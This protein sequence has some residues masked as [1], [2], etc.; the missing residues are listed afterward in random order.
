VTTVEHSPAL[1]TRCAA[2]AAQYDCEGWQR[3]VLAKDPW[4][5]ACNITSLCPAAAV[6]SSVELKLY[7]NPLNPNNPTSL[8]IYRASES[9]VPDYP[10]Q[11]LFRSELTD[12]QFPELPCAINCVMEK[13]DPS[14]FMN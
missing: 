3:P 5:N 14:L 1:E 4:E 6:L 10:V 8:Y 12:P 7:T 13:P 2:S 9:K 11:Y